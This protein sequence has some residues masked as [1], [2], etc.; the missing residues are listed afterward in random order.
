[1]GFN[2]GILELIDL[3][4]RRIEMIYRPRAVMIARRGKVEENV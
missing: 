3:T 2:I 4:V 1:M